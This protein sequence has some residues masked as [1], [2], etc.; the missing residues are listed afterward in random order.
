MIKFDPDYDH[1]CLASI[2][3]RRKP[4]KFCARELAFEDSGVNLE[5]CLPPD[6]NESLSP[7]FP[8]FVA[9]RRK[10]FVEK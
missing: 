5:K 8:F 1:P 2:I 9:L 7:P 10:A 6:G 4:L 3:L